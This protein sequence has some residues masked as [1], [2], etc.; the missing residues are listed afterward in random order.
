MHKDGAAREPK[1]SIAREPKKRVASKGGA[2]LQ[3]GHGVRVT[4]Q[5]IAGAVPEGE[6][7][8]DGGLQPTV[9]VLHHRCYHVSGGPLVGDD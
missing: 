5:R 7:Y 6:H 4:E 2:C 9:S 8:L 1:K 3:F